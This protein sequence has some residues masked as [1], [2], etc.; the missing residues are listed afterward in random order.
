MY[1]PKHFQNHNTDDL[2]ALIKAYP[3]ATLVTYSAQGLE[4][5]HIPL[6]AEA[7]EAGLVLT[8]HIARANSLWQD[9]EDNCEALAIFQ[10][11]QHYI[12]PSAYPAKKEHGKVV[13]TWNYMTVHIK[14]RL[15]FIHCV[16]WKKAFLT[17]LVNEHE[18]SE[19]MPWALDDAPDS[20]IE[21]QLNAIVGIELEVLA[22]E[23]KWKLSQNQSQAAREG[24][25]DWLDHKNSDEAQVMSKIMQPK[26]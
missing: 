18:A 4:A 11:P 15:R 26:P 19:A 10:G 14:S 24:V 23:S 1:S 12:S 2:I 22:M 6:H 20:F 16:Q 17:Q 9:L 25:V 13:P 8:G 5:N 3:L 7:S 21:K